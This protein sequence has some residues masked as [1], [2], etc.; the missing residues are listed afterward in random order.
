MQSLR[1]AEEDPLMRILLIAN[2]CLV[3]PVV[4]EVIF[5]GY[6]YGVLKRFTG[7]IFAAFISASLFA[8]AHNNL[9]AVLP[10]WGF[11][12]F[13][14][15]FYEASRCLWVPIGMHAVFNAVQVFRLLDGNGG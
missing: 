2:A 4:E 6:L 1:E 7:A 12:L 11:A 15:L 13:L 14:T 3:A 8:V 5:R 9:P 10:L